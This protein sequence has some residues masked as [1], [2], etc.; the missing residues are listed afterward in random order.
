MM[1]FQEAQTKIAE[2]LILACDKC[3]AAG[4]NPLYPLEMD[5]SFQVLNCPTHG[6]R[7]PEPPTNY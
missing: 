5:E 7:V 3:F 6:Q 4:A 2:G 1:T